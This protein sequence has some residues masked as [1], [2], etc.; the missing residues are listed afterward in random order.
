MNSSAPVTNH[1]RF[2]FLKSSIMPECERLPRGENVGR[3]LCPL[4]DV[5]LALLNWL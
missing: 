5:S 3:S 1:G 2:F 4:K